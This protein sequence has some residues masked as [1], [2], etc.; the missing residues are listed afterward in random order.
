MRT[1]AIIFLIFGMTTSGMQAQE[2][3]PIWKAQMST[4]SLLMGNR[5]KVTFILKNGEGRNFEPPSFAGFQVVGGPNQSS[6]MS[7]VNGNMSREASFSFY[8]MPLEEGNYFIDPAII[9]VEGKP[10]ETTPLEVIVFPNPDGVKQEI[11]NANPGLQW[12]N[13]PWEKP[14]TP[15]IDGKKKRK[16]YRT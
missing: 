4:D 8:L 6:S 15:R 5:L 1:I 13:L 14:E 9:N 10:Y 16:I 12:N 7:I 2:N 11:P 3:A